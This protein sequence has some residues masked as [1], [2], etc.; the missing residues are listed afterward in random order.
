MGHTTRRGEKMKNMLNEKKH[1]EAMDDDDHEADG[2]LH[3]LMEGHKIKNNPEMMERV[4]ARAGR[5]MKAL[6]G[7]MSK[8]EKITSTDQLRELR[9]KKAM[10][11][12]DDDYEF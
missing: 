2:A 5:K 6:K 8:K 4:K 11:K 1:K 3:T 7:L 10:A 9:N 12:D